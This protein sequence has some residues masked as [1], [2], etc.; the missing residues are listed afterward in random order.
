MLRSRTFF[1]RVASISINQLR[2]DE[3]RAFSQRTQSLIKRLFPDDDE[4]FPILQR[5]FVDRRRILFRS[6]KGGDPAPNTVRGQKTNGPGFGGHGGSIILRGSSMV[7][8]LARLPVSDVISADAGGDG[9]GT[10]RGIHANDT[11]I[12][13]PLGTIVRERVKTDRKTDEGRA[14]YAPKFVYQFLRDDDTLILCNG[15]KGG[16]APQTFKKGDGR[17]GS[18]GE[19][20]SIDL[21]L[22]L[23]NDCCLLGIPN[24]GKSSIISALT[25]TQ[26]RI[27]P[28][29]YSTTRPH[30]GTLQF[31][32]GL[33]VTLLDLP[34]LVEGSFSD[35]ERGIRV[36]RHTYRSKLLIYCVDVSNQEIDPFDQLE[37]L[38]SEVRSYNPNNFP[39]RKEIIIATKCDMLHRDTLIN[40]DSLFFRVQ[41]RHGDHIPVIGTSARFGLGINHLV[42]QIR[43]SLYPDSV[44][45]VRRRPEV[46]LIVKP[47]IESN[48]SYSSVA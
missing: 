35:K 44:G 4:S 21:E 38:R 9:A 19:K 39:S 46:T 17:K 34:G 22:R 33:A 31:R 14:I 41:A 11:I 32:D 23:V 3:P 18:P 40:I 16:V 7:E 36:L 30:L 47:E 8:S 5:D 10:S 45:E 48:N 37:L 6:G 42:H 43:Q 24:S 28:E 27:G 29:P 12:D 13:V 2:N 15:G 25:S 26:T 20:K 1:H